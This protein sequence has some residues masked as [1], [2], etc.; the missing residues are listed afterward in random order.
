[1]L[2]ARPV[3]RLAFRSWPRSTPAC[4][5]PTAAAVWSLA[6]RP[7]ACQIWRANSPTVGT[8]FRGAARAGRIVR[9]VISAGRISHRGCFIDL[10]PLRLR[11]T[12]RKN[13]RTSIDSC[14]RARRKR[15][16]CRDKVAPL[17]RR[18][19]VGIEWASDRRRRHLRP[20]LRRDRPAEGTAP[21]HRPPAGALL[22]AVAMVAWGVIDFETA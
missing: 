14:D 22:G 17:R 7:M 20:D 21:P 13:R 16:G 6:C 8:P 2:T 5:R 15:P 10:P 4:V 11:E 9:T 1:M 12:Y 18:A 19:G 3:V